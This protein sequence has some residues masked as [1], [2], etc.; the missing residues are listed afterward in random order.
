[1]FP[2]HASTVF[3][4]RKK[5]MSKCLFTLACAFALCLSPASADLVTPSKSNGDFIPG[6]GIPG[7][8]FYGEYDKGA[9]L[10]FKARG[11]LTGQPLAQNGNRFTV[12][13]G[14][15]GNTTNPWW[16]FDFQFD[17]GANA[18]N[19]N[20]YTFTIQIDTNPAVGI[21]NF[22]TLTNSVGDANSNP[23][24]SWDDTDSFF[25]NP[26]GGAW[27]SSTPWIVANSWRM[28]FGFIS[29]TFDPYAAGEYE[30]RMSA[31]Q[32]RE[33]VNLVGFVQVVPVPSGIVLA[34]MGVAI[35]GLYAWRRK[36]NAPL[37]AGV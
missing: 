12:Q 17:P 13:Y 6:S 34:G 37:L 20:S 27:T 5:K 29:P 15:A 3:L 24:D 30:F 32:G 19:P 9:S 23:A 22:V 2:V 25:T 18:G 10:F 35:A 21:A 26:G 4:W 1:M 31:N 33:L 11:R 28:N 36:K 16:N 8:N 7:N 14:Y